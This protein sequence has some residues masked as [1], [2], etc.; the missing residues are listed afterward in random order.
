MKIIVWCERKVEKST[1]RH[2]IVKQVS[3]ATNMHVKAGKLLGVNFNNRLVACQPV[4][5]QRDAK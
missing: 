5:R 3:A 2:R 4:A 1:A